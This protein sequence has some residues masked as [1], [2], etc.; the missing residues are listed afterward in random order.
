MSKKSNHIQHTFD[1]YMEFTQKFQ[2]NTTTHKNRTDVFNVEKVEV[3][4]VKEVSHE[5]MKECNS[6]GYS[7]QSIP[8]TTGNY[9]IYIT[10]IE[11]TIETAK[12][13]TQPFT[14]MLIAATRSVK[15][16]KLLK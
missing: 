3:D 10:D 6:L 7:I 16:N 5:L 9:R 4:V 13:V 14:Q 15:L 12:E 2:G 1:Y 11:R 8:L